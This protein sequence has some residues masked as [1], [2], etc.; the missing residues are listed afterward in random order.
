M[1]QFSSCQRMLLTE[2][3]YYVNSLCVTDVGFM[4]YDMRYESNIYLYVA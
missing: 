2:M 3:S 4:I 1:N